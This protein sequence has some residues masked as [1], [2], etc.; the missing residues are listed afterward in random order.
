MRIL[1]GILL[2]VVAVAILFGIIVIPVLPLT[3]DNAS[4]DNYLAALLCKSGEKMVREQYSTRDSRG[5]SYSMTPYCVNSER[6]R[7]DV[8][9]KW[10]LYGAG[11][12]VVPFLVGL[13]LIIVGANRAVRQQQAAIFESF[14]QPGTHANVTVIKGSTFNPQVDFTDGVLKVNGLKIRMEDLSPDKVEVLKT[15]FQ[16]VSG[17]TDL[18]AKLKQIQDA[19]DKGLISYDEYER[20]RQKI[21][22]DVT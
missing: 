22:D 21:L 7:E 9:G 1:A 12:F 13:T 11:G 6:Q 18:S 14:G 5:T 15:H 8:S 20:L 2:I 17:T 10:V 16:S 3:Q 4:V 19:K